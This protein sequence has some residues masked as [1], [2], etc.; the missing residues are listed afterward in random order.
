[1][2]YSGIIQTFI[3]RR[4]FGFIR[5]DDGKEFFF[6]QMDFEKGTPALGQRVEFEL[7]PAVRLGM[8]EQAVNVTPEA[9]AIDVLAGNSTTSSTEVSK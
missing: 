3:T 1:M 7:G 9:D 8:P 4:N 5:R 6:H 2:R